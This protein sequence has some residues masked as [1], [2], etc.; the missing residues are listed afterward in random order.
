[1][2]IYDRRRN[3]QAAMRIDIG[4]ATVFLDAPSGVVT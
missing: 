2:L 1:M 4:G 3:L